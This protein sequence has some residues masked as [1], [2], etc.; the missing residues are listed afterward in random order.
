MKLYHGTSLHRLKDI[1]KSKGL[2]PRGRRKGNWDHTVKSRKDAVY[3]TNAFGVHFASAAK[4]RNIPLMIV[5]VDTSLL[6]EFD[7]GPDEDFLEQASRDTP[8]FDIGEGMQKRTQWFVERP[9][10]EFQHLWERSIESLGSCCVRHG[11][12][13]EAI[14]RY[15]L[16]PQNHPVLGLSDPTI[17]LTAYAVV[18]AFYRNLTKYVFG[19]YDFEEDFLGYTNVLIDAARGEGLLAGEPS[20]EWKANRKKFTRQGIMVGDFPR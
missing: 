7:I 3:L 1:K 5:E 17:G 4:I 18:G 13:L 14:T 10:F 9:W 19:D 8:G 20:D 15:A 11:V 6:L 12:P 16:I 2:L